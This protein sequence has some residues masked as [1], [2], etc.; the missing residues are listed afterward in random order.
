MTGGSCAGGDDFKAYSFIHKYGISDDTCLPFRGV[1]D[2]YELPSDP[3]VRQVQSRLCRVCHW[4]GECKWEAYYPR[5]GIEQFGKGKG[6]L[7]YTSDA[8]DE[9]DSVDLGGW[10]VLKKNKEEG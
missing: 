1:A 2:H 9:E 10:P 7:L 6:C 4:N 5:Y 8:A 3:S